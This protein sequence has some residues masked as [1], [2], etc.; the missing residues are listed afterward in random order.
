[1]LGC[2]M[3]VYY[4]HFSFVNALNVS[5]KDLMSIKVDPE[6]FASGKWQPQKRCALETIEHGSLNVIQEKFEVSSYA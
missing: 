6:T 2:I 1:M 5:V 4:F 3:S